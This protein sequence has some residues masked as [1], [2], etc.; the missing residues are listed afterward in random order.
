MAIMDEIRRAGREKK[1]LKIQ[2]RKLN[3]EV[4]ERIVEPYEIKNARLWAYDIAKDD[5]IR[6]F[7]ITGILTAQVLEQTFVERN[8]WPVKIR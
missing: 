1:L 3:G 4:S 6:N 2:Y 7:I 5:N 8:N